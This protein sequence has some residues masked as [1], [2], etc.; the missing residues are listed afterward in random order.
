MRSQM[1]ATRPPLQIQQQFESAV[2]SKP[3]GRKAASIQRE[4]FVGTDLFR[5]PN[6]QRRKVSPATVATATR[7]GR[8]SGQLNVQ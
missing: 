1:Q 7:T 6:A 8:L 4:H 3:K 2:P 5:H